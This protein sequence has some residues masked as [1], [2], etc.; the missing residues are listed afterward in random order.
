[1]HQELRHWTHADSRTYPGLFQQMVSL[2]TYPA[3][4]NVTGAI[5]LERK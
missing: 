4:Y 1:M 5:V 2:A 3:G